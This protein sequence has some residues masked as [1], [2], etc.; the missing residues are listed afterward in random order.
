M[1]VGEILIFKLWGEEIFNFQA[2]GREVWHPR[3][4]CLFLEQWKEQKA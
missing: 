4:G 1:S 2:V 3:L